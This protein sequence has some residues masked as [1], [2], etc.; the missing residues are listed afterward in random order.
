MKQYKFTN[1]ETQVIY[2]SRTENILFWNDW[3]T[4]SD[5]TIAVKREYSWNGCKPKFVWLDIMWGTPDGKMIDTWRGDENI[6]RCASMVHNALYQFKKEVYKEGVTRKM[7]DQIFYDIMKQ[8]GFKL[9]KL[10]YLIARAFG[11]MFGKWS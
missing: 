4:I 9:A 2:N 1:R 11:W 10:Y 6:T 3:L 7:A 5:G 8:D